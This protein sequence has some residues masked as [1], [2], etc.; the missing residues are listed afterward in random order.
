MLI[1]IYVTLL[2]CDS[3]RQI[4]SICSDETMQIVRLVYVNMISFKPH[5]FANLIRNQRLKIRP[6]FLGLL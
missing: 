5:V 3:I 4:I 1:K 6:A 2:V